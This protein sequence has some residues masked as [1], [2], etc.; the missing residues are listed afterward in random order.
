MVI[1]FINLPSRNC[2]RRIDDKCGVGTIIR[3]LY[4]FSKVAVT[5]VTYPIRASEFSNSHVPIPDWIVCGA[6]RFTPID[7]KLYVVLRAVR[8]NLEANLALQAQHFA[9]V[10]LFR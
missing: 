6:G 5:A 4:N 3:V 7:W 2:F 10:L 1:P 9:R 8:T